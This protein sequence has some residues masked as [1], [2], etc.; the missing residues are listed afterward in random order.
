MHRTP[1]TPGRSGAPLPIALLLA[2]VLLAGGVQA[3]TIP[4][5]DAALATGADEIVRGEIANVSCRWNANH[6]QITT[7]VDVRVKARAKGTGPETLTLT[8]PGGTVDGVTEW[9][10]DQP[11]LAPGA[12]AFVFVRHGAAGSRVYGG[13]EGAVPIERGRVRGTGTAKGAGISADAYERYIGALA[14]GGAA[15]APAAEPAPRA[16]GGTTPVIASVSPASGSAGTGT[17]IVITGTGFGNRSSRDS[18]A[19]VGF[20][21]RYDGTAVTPIWASGF[22][23]FDRNEDDILSWSDSEIRVRVPSGYTPDR[24]RESAS[25]GFV[26][27]LTEQNAASA[28]RPFAVTF[29]YG[30]AK[31]QR[32]DTVDYRVYTRTLGNGAI[33][34]ITNAAATWNAA[35]PNG[36][37]RFAYGGEST[38]IDHGWDSTNLIYLGSASD[39]DNPTTLALTYR[40]ILGDEVL[41]CDTVLNPAYTWTTGY[42]NSSSWNLEM[43]VVHELGHWLTLSDLYGFVPGYPSDTGK[44]MFGYAGDAFGNRNR[45]TLGPED[46][47]GIRWIYGDGSSLPTPTPTATPG[48]YPGPHPVPGRVQAEDYDSGGEGVAYHDTEPANLGGAYRTTEGVDVETGG[49]ITD[50]GWVRSGEWLSYT[51]NATAPQSVV[52]RL[53]ASNPDAAKQ[54]RISAN[55]AVVGS[56]TLPPTGSFAT[57]TTADSTP[58]WL[59]TGATTIRLSFDGVDRANLDW[60]ELAPAVLPSTTITHGPT[61][62]PTIPPT[63]PPTTTPPTPTPTPALVISAPGRYALDRD[64]SA[65]WNG[66]LI[67]SSDVVLDGMGHAVEGP[68][69][70]MAYMQGAEAGRGVAVQGDVRFPPITNV[71]V[72]NLSVRHWNNGIHIEHAENVTVGGIVGEENGIG[73]HDSYSQSAVIRDSVFRESGFPGEQNGVGIDLY[74]AGGAVIE[75]CSVRGNEIGI[76]TSDWFEGAPNTIADC[77]ASSNA[78]EGIAIGDGGGT[79]VRNCTVQGNGE[80]G[81]QTSESP[82]RVLGNRLEGNG[83]AGVSLWSRTNTVAGNR[84]A[85]NAAG[86]VAQFGSSGEV[87]NNVLNNTV[88]ADLGGN[89]SDY[90]LNATRSAGPNIVGGLSIG[91]NFWAN[92]DGTGFSETH[93]DADGDGFCDE[94]FVTDQ[95]GVDYLPLAVPSGVAIP[96]GAGRPTDTNGDGLYDDVNGNGRRDF[97]DVVLYFNQLSWIAANEPMAFF[98]YNAN[99]RIDFSDVVWLFNH[100]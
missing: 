50:V 29:G 49:G 11:V 70:L 10:E 65:D 99:G 17:E 16:A 88:N 85:G 46:V 75:R 83:D 14:A 87:W 26:W 30:E 39:F 55:G 62:T 91:G 48:P 22:P 66:V 51:V 1:V 77:D 76:S 95:G 18:N 4:M 96:G 86:I 92:P 19:D 24:A 80:S 37:L 6:T 58:L 63:T 20:V 32:R 44:V 5:D 13:S 52:L 64:L 71:M 54:V 93:A 38:W 47:A 41:D 90:R 2:L 68:G 56:V 40:V 97:A 21:Y 73:L 53:R 35:L 67:T 61:P 25:S 28:S 12:E 43:V 60:L 81:I 8:V 7:S 31:W 89:A 15:P 23:F 82:V 33:D 9:V 84:I 27:V 45:R 79:T 42:A 69:F 59:P 100:L 78:R 3:L 36:S 74:F 57:Y 98:D 34:A 72:L 94:P